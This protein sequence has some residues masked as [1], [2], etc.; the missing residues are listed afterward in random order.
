[1]STTPDTLPLVEAEHLC[2]R[3]PVVGQRGDRVHALW[4]VLRGRPPRR[5]ASVL[6]DISFSVRPGESLGIIGENGAGKSTLLKLVT[7]VLTPSA[8]SVATR[9]SVGALLELGAGFHPEYSGIDNVRMSAAL[10]GLSGDALAEKLPD[11]LAFA[12][13]GDYIHEPVKHYSSGMVVRLGFA[14]IASVRPQLLITDEVLAVGDESFQRKCIRWMDD[15]LAGGGTLMLVSH[16]IYHIQKLCR[17]ALW[18]ADGRVRAHGD[19]FEVTQAYVAWHEQKGRVQIEEEQS[20]HS[21]SGEFAIDE[22]LLNGDGSLGQII[23]PQESPLLVEAIAR[24][25]DGRPPALIVGIVRADGSPVYGVGSDMDAVTPE[26]LGGNRFRYRIAFDALPLLPGQYLLRVH[27]LDPEGVRLFGT[28]E[29]VFVIRGSTRE[30]GMI[31]LAH[32]WLDA[33]EQP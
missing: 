13:I 24:S 2:K 29:R 3:Y 25:A 19:V 17:Q 11:I 4:D 7:G 22:V 32:R 18:L 30:M 10:R 14:V 8:G 12:D 31:R 27:P 16:G 6:E 20:A 28:T 26:A 9:G 21:E 15:Y 23:L 5:V 1:M 33:T